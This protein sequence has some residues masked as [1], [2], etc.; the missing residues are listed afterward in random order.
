MFGQKSFRINGAECG[1]EAILLGIITS[2]GGFLFGYDTGQI[3]GMLL[4]EDFIN[5]FGQDQADGT[6]DFK[7]IIESL[8]VSLMSIGTLVGSLTSSYTADWFGRRKSLSFGVLIFII[9]SIIQITAQNSWVHMMMGRFVAGLGIG[10][11]SVGVPMFQSECAPRQIRGA[12]VASYQ[13]MITFGILVSNC[14]NYGVR[15][16][17]DSPPPGASSSASA[18]P[19]LYPSASASSPCPSPRWLAARSRWDDA[20]LSLARLRGLRND[21]HNRFA[22]G[23]G[24][25]RE[26]V[27]P[28]PNGIPKQVYRTLLGVSLHFIQQWTGVN[29]F[30]YYGATI[31]E[32]AGIDDPIRTQLILGAINVGMTFLGLYV[33]EKFGRRWPLIIGAIWQAVWLTVFASMGT[34][35]NPEENDTSGIIMIVSASMFIASFAA[36]WGPICWVVIGE[37]FPLRTRSKQASL[38]TA[39]N[40]LG[41]FMI[42]FLTPLATDGISYAYGYV[43]VGMNVVGAIVVWFFLYE[44]VSLSL[45]NVD[46]MYS[47]PSVKAWKSRSWVPPG[48]INRKDKDESERPGPLPPPPVTAAA[49][50]TPISLPALRAAPRMGFSM[51]TREP[52][53][54]KCLAWS[55]RRK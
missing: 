30:F 36:T 32:S 16:I 48:Y 40:W 45:E 28:K 35:L 14:V 2:M 25:W 43:F 8:V 44:S 12:V 46:L 18:S 50:A 34:A 10:N 1:L 5:R 41:N 6:R 52:G 15:E 22:V 55:T 23:V 3:S 19:S 39:F 31:F 24:S 26:C 49:T 17:E 53:R 47:D 51:P 11:L 13:L 9:G 38:A 27:I 29:Y 33:V 37:T 54:V 7:P 21:P 20:R 42:S 4:F